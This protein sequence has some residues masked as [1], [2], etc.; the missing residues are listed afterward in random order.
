MILYRYR[1]EK[2]FLNHSWEL[3]GKKKNKDKGISNPK[4]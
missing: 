3:K 2:F 1:K 4:F